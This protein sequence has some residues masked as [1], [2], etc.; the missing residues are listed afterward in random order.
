[1]PIKCDVLVVGGGPAGCS[2]A[3]AAAKQGAKTI[4]IEK[5]KEINKISCAEGIGSYLFPLLP[6]K[7]PK[8]QLIWRIDGFS[9]SDG[10]TEII[11]KGNF[12]RGWSVDRGKFDNWLLTN[13]KNNGTQ[14]MMDTELTD[15]KFSK[16]DHAKQAITQS[17]NK[18]K[19]IEPNII[20]AADGVESTVAKI[21]GNLKKTTD[22]IGHIY[23]W[24]MKNVSLKYQHFEQ[25][26]LG[27]FA[28]R[29]YAYVFPK[30]KNTANV[31]VGSSKGDKNLEKYFGE[32]A[33]EIIPSQIKNAIKTVDR[34]GKAPIKYMN[35][36]ITYGNVL[37]TGDAAN[38]NFKPYIEGILPSIICGDIAGKTACLKNV[39]NYE[40][41]IKRK[42]GNQFRHSDKLLENVYNYD[43]LPKKKKN[44][45]NM[46][47]FAF[48]DIEKIE[49]LKDKDTNVIKEELFRKSHNVNSFITMLQYLIWYTKV[50]ATR[51]D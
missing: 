49:S 1:M 13:A 21:I 39:N 15:I 33:N 28:P 6:F 47:F 3:R 14:I 30:S 11:Q 16:D 19:I 35:P 40:K 9:F 8:N 18:T 17:K 37:F 12:Y 44:L 42:L 20:I 45:I 24:E 27:D 31:G 43:H 23:S 2:A 36:K 29:A 5:K 32:F 48:G 7:I 34:S 51:R 10:K 26:Y 22:S 46:Y 25:M 50:L 38:Q 4:L 41:L